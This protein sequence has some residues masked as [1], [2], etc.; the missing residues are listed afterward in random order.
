MRPEYIKAILRPLGML[1]YPIVLITDGEDPTVEQRLKDDPEIGPMLRL[2]PA[3]NSWI[4]GD[5][6]LATMSNVFIG[7]P[8]SSF[9]EFFSK[10][11]IAFGF[12]HNHL[13]RTTT[14]DGG[15]E[16]WVTTCGDTCIYDKAVMGNMS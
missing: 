2:V 9:S 8:A 13:F 16:D 10:A 3:D 15:E 11:R 5:I 6:T 12:G 7:N 1:Q 14:A 4:G